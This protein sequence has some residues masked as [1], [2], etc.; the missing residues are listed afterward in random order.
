M[1]GKFVRNLSLL[2]VLNLL[3]K[4]F[5]ILGI[6]RS[7]QNTVG[8]E[9]YGFYFAVFNFSF[10]FN[11]LLDFGITNFN[12]KNIAQNN[13]LLT[14]YLS[15]LLVLKLLLFLVYIAVTLSGALFINYSQEQIRLLYFLGL[16]QFL[17]SMILY[18]RS[19][20]GGLHLFRTDS[21]IS[22]LDRSLMIVICALLL[23]GNVVEEFR[24][25]YYI[26]AQTA[27]Y[28][29][30][31]VV[32]FMLV[33][34]RTQRINFRLQWNYPFLLAIVRKSFPF[35]IL[36]LLMTFYNRIDSV[37]LER[38]LDDGARYSGIYASAYR[39]LDA[40]NMIAYL[41]AV[42]LLPIFARMIKQQEN[43][44]HLL[45][46]AFTLIIAPAIIIA[47]AAFF[48]S[49]EIMELLYPMHPGETE[50]AYQYR[51][52]ESSRV[53]GLLMSCFIAISTTYIF[54]TLLTANGN[55]WHLNII[56]LSGMMLNITLNFILIPQFQATGS[57][58]SSL[59]TQLLVAVIQVIAVKRIF[60]IHVNYSFLMRLLVFVVTIIGINMLW[61]MLS[62]FTW[63][64]NIPLV[65]IAGL[66]LALALRLL[67]LR[68][69]YQ[70]MKYA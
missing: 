22:V 43:I 59:F 57:A 26:Y 70:L 33:L 55:L 20:L 34:A 13:H 15:N 10:L 51:M 14:K 37:M 3:I 21:I 64:F 60:R 28:S 63:L 35:A 4:P 69:I 23:W 11:I 12:N 45:K 47:S 46:L 44:E 17:I 68:H 6:D 42:L 38:L 2:L 24:I 32:T 16:N 61:S 50:L 7:V 29:I 40:T 27:G 5:W 53:F 1:Q 62:P 58:V 39:L 25:Q 9:E 48:Y 19:N 67:S 41:F 30:T 36:V 56:A 66:L 54:G 52:L 8:A 18:L 31:A 65:G 49:Q